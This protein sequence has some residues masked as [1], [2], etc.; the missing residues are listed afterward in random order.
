[1]YKIFIILIVCIIFL[2]VIYFYEL[3]KNCSNIQLFEIKGPNI[4]TNKKVIVVNLNKDI[5][6]IQNFINEI[7][8]N[9]NYIGYKNNFVKVI[10]KNNKFK[11]IIDYDDKL[12][13]K[14]IIEYSYNNKGNIEKIKDE[15]NN[16]KIGPST[17]AILIYANQK[18]IPWFRLNKN[19]LIQLGW[20]SKQKRIE[21]STSSNTFAISEMIVK[22]K[23]ITK[24]MLKSINIPVSDGYIVKNKDELIKY[25][26][27]ILL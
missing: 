5:Q 21:A 7:K 26:N 25:F 4:Y 18:S 3:K 24:K 9:N 14:K 1:M 17:N 2:I 27:I 8:N 12:I 23:N 20:G 6:N 19:N 11:I 13:A 22:N 15:Y 10:K 16:I